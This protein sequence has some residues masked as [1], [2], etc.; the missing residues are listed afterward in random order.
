M[1]FPW[2]KHPRSKQPDTMLTF[3]TWAVLTA[4]FKFLMNGTILI[5]GSWSYNFGVI[6]SM[7][8][9]AILTPTLGAYVARKWKDSPDAT[10]ESKNASKS[11]KK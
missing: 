4:L 7:L 6:D 1:N 9:A 3:S 2:I 8:M 11:L 10:K 5:I